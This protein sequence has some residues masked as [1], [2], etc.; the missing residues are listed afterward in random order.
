MQSC[1][2]KLTLFN[3][4]FV[5]DKYKLKAARRVLLSILAKVW[6]ITGWL[7]SF[8]NYYH[9]EICGICWKIIV[10]K[11]LESLYVIKWNNCFVLM[12]YFSASSA[13]SSTH[14]SGIEVTEVYK[15]Y[16][17]S[18][19]S[20]FTKFSQF[21]RVW[22]VC[23]NLPSPLGCSHTMC[24]ANLRKPFQATIDLQKYYFECLEKN[25]VCW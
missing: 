6:S 23:F 11:Q 12:L 13:C 19:M 18:K 5:P 9:E 15:R 14:V 7:G 4:G 17:G 2:N 10:T 21:S 1:W 22:C 16:S 25:Y 20:G 3:L 24:K 8:N